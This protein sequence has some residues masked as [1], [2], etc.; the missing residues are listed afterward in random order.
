MSHGKRSS[1]YPSILLVEDEYL[2]AAGITTMVREMGLSVCALV[3]SGEEALELVN[4]E[5]PDLVLMDVVLRGRLTGTE[6]A[7]R[8]RRHC[9]AP[10]IFMS[11]H[12]REQI[13][14]ELD[15]EGVMILPK[16]FTRDH[17]HEALE[18]ALPL[19]REG[20]RRRQG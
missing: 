15:L 11:A 20:M 19:A 1:L 5:Q 14:G 6:T 16:P 3:A 2:V 18:Q 7:R 10:I 13:L 4:Q 12:P 8:I 17:L 9:P